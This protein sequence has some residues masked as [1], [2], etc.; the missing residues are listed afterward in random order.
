MFDSP[1]DS[2]HKEFVSREISI[3][4][5]KGGR[6]RMLLRR[7]LFLSCLF[8]GLPAGALAAIPD[9]VPPPYSAAVLI[10]PSAVSGGLAA[11]IPVEF[12]EFRPR[13]PAEAAKGPT[14]PEGLYWD[15][16][17]GY[18]QLLS[19]ANNLPCR[20]YQLSLPTML[21]SS[22]RTIMRSADPRTF[23][24]EK[25]QAALDVMATAIVGTT[26]HDLSELMPVPYDVR[27]PKIS[28]SRTLLALSTSFTP[29]TTSGSWKIEGTGTALVR[30]LRD[31][32]LLDAPVAAIAA[33]LGALPPYDKQVQEAKAYAVAC[34]EPVYDVAILNQAEIILLARPELAKCR[35]WLGKVPPGKRM[36]QDLTPLVRKDSPEALP[37]KLSLHQGVGPE[38]M[39]TGDGIAVPALLQDPPAIQVQPSL[40]STISIARFEMAM[41][42]QFLRGWRW[43]QILRKDVIRP[44]WITGTGDEEWQTIQ[45]LLRLNEPLF[46]YICWATVDMTADNTTKLGAVEEPDVVDV[47][48]MQAEKGTA[49]ARATVAQQVD[50]LYRSRLTGMSE[51]AFYPT[52]GSSLDNRLNE[53]LVKA[54][55]GKPEELADQLSD[56]IADGFTRASRPLPLREALEQMHAVEATTKVVAPVLEPDLVWIMRSL[57]EPGKERAHLSR[58]LAALRET[59]FSAA[60]DEMVNLN[61]VVAI[62]WSGP[63]ITAD[64][65]A[66]LIIDKDSMKKEFLRILNFAHERFAER[67]DKKRA[68]KIKDA[69]HGYGYESTWWLKYKSS[70]EDLQ[71]AEAEKDWKYFEHTRKV[72]LCIG[73]I[74]RELTARG[75]KPI[76]VSLKRNAQGKYECP[77]RDKDFDNL[78]VESALNSIVECCRLQAA[79]AYDQEGALEGFNIRLRGAAAEDLDKLLR[80]LWKEFLI[81]KGLKTPFEKFSFHKLKDR[82]TVVTKAFE[83]GG[84]RALIRLIK[85]DKT[86][87]E[88]R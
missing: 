2:W 51:D 58:M 79:N 53:T 36:L 8:L 17:M 12:T 60:M 29:V 33:K 67:P 24:D 82:L 11:S 59:H 55:D 9:G 5:E 63:R 16:E 83:S 77:P 74:Y 75:G 80:Q 46:D 76:L 40:Q 61:H 57:N 70:S 62:E 66:V 13:N 27:P 64:N 23:R 32:Q 41:M 20:V 84:T 47:K 39:S 65:A 78:I 35:I 1:T 10:A 37:L 85:D 4:P 54:L 56:L 18:G 26:G 31:E 42:H 15:F 49:R 14:L 68:T 45:T 71:T 28:G 81:G 87:E 25:F 88:L 86:V 69:G 50:E 3:L 72:E 43:R 22:L 44:P 34:T 7:A 21:K 48:H 6:P 52:T 30:A 19:E 38:M 73:M